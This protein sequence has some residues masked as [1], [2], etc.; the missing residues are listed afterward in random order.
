MYRHELIRLRVGFV[1]LAAVLL[2]PLGLLVR[3]AEARFDAQ[4]RL[5]HEIVAERIF[6]EMER[7][8]TTLLE[9]E[10]DRPSS[11]YESDDTHP[12]S[13]SPFVVGYFRYDG[14]RVALA[15][16]GQLSAERAARVERALDALN[17]RGALA[18]LLPESPSL[19]EEYKQTIETSAQ[20]PSVEQRQQQGASTVG[21]MTPQK[22]S[23]KPA[24]Q[25]EAQALDEAVL[26]KLNRAG[27]ERR[28]R[29]E[30]KAKGAPAAADREAA[31]DP[32]SGF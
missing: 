23:R 15:A 31:A 6:D 25:T 22:K 1:L 18:G 28:K 26:Q 3:E 19:Q 16:R 14:E 24:Q 8:L 2:V 9:V 10:N 4:R 29:A 13:W 17:A 5:R 21:V 7:E 12:S 32:L 11:A 20:A 30:Q 27:V